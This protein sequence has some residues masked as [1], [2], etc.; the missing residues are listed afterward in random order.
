MSRDRL[1]GNTIRLRTG[2]GTQSEHRGGESEACGA[3]TARPMP[4]HAPA[5]GST[6]WSRCARAGHRYP[7]RV[8]V[9]GS[10]LT[11]IAASRRGCPQSA[12][13]ARTVHHGAVSRSRHQGARIT[14]LGPAESCPHPNRV[15]DPPSD[16]ARGTA[17][18]TAPRRCPLRYRQ[19]RLGRP[20]GPPHRPPRAR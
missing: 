1:R 17:P 13:P 12:V 20:R 10:T 4:Y 2:R 7:R 14:W 16:G 6:R 8:A 18:G 3:H 15:R 19:R 5:T 9:S 11:R